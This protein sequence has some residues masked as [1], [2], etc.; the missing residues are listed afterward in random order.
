MLET[1]ITSNLAT[2]DALLDFGKRRQFS[3]DSTSKQENEKEKNTEE[4]FY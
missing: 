4:A 3:G 1:V 2:C